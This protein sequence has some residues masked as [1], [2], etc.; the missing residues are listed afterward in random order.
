MATNPKNLLVVVR[1]ANGTLKK[2]SFSVD[3]KYVVNESVQLTVLE[4]NGSRIPQDILLKRKGNDLLIEVSGQQEVFEV[5]GFYSNK[6]VVMPDA[7]FAGPALDLSQAIAN[8]ATG[9][10]VWSA[11]ATSATSWAPLGAIG[12]GAIAAAGGSGGGSSNNPPPLTIDT[13]SPELLEE[14]IVAEL[15]GAPLG[16]S[17]TVDVGA[18]LIYTFTFNEDI[19]ESSLT[20]GDFSNAAEGGAAITIGN[21]VRVAPGVFTVEVTPTSAGSLQIQVTQGA[22][23]RDLAGNSIDTSTAILDQE[24]LDVVAVEPELPSSRFIS[25]SGINQSGPNVW[26][27]VDSNGNFDAG[28]DVELFVDQDETLRLG[29]EGGTAISFTTGDW[30]VKFW[31]ALGPTIDLAGFNG[32]DAV[33]VDMSRYSNDSATM[34]STNLFRLEPYFM[35]L[36]GLGATGVPGTPGGYQYS[37]DGQGILW[38]GNSGYGF[39]AL[40]VETNISDGQTNLRWALGTN[41]STFSSASPGSPVFQT[42]RSAY[43]LYPISTGVLARNLGGANVTYIM[44]EWPSINNIIA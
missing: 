29:S 9:E 20:A 30:T 43:N 18:P 41:F 31:D 33:I 15:N 21:I 26:I 1:E 27:D 4:K 44:P 2:L 5:Q 36:E 39:T 14:D 42:S 25:V 10:I 11:G 22:D 24:T 13:T 6:A 17:E 7:S 12:L 34:T 23:I 35:G 28:E 19:D 38:M 16:D 37:R 8:S 3:K 40:A 32:E